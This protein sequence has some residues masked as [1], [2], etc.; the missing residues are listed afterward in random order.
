[1]NF[2]PL[3]IV[4][5]IIKYLPA[6]YDLIAFSLVCRKFYQSIDL[7]EIERNLPFN[8]IKKRYI[9]SLTDFILYLYQQNP[10]SIKHL[11]KTPI[12]LKESFLD[13]Y[14]ECDTVFNH[15]YYYYFKP[16]E[17]DIRIYYEHYIPLKDKY[18]LCLKWKFFQIQKKYSYCSPEEQNQLF[19]LLKSTFTFIKFIRQT[20]MRDFRYLLVDDDFN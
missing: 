13:T 18:Q 11:S 3:L 8:P 2:F 6:F 14:K 17:S 4:N 12:E 15:Y 9:Q 19:E 5:K 1:M 20:Q 7:I 10:D 16:W